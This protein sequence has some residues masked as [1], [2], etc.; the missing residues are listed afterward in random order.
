M[1]RKHGW[2]RSFFA[3][4]LLC[5]VVILAQEPVQNVDP[6]RHPNLAEAQHHIAE[7]NRLIIVA[8][9][10]NHL[11]MHGHAEKARQLLVQASEEIKLGAE[12]ANRR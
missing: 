5:G 8:Q 2:I 4:V 12:A 11:D 10:E 9:K 3:A 6:K 7:A 1:T